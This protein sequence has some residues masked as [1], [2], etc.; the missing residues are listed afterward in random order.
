MPVKDM[1]KYIELS[2][3]CNSTFGVSSTGKKTSESVM[4]K[5]VDDETLSAMFLIVVNYS[6]EAMWIEMRKRWIEEGIEIISKRLKEIE[7]EFKTNTGKTIKLNVLESTLADSLELESY[8]V[9]K[10]IKTGFF[11]L[12]C[13]VNVV[14]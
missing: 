14:E 2:K 10:P 8:S 4:V 11:R 7:Q 12:R 1:K 13:N 3:V 5:P 6:S 9:Y